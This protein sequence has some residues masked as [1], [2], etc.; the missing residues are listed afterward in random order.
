MWER[1][2]SH[3][4]FAENSGF[5]RTKKIPVSFDTRIF[6]MVGVGGFELPTSCSQSRRATGLRYTPVKKRRPFQVAFFDQCFWPLILRFDSSV[7]WS[8]KW[9][10]VW[11]SNL[12][13][14]G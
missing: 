7:N 14:I 3:I 13:P 12:R 1:A 10:V 6:N 4:C 8:Q 11:D 5:A 9:W 2:C